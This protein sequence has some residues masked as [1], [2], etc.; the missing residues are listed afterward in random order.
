[1]DKDIW[2]FMLK[3]WEADRRILQALTCLYTTSFKCCK[4]AL[5]VGVLRV[6]CNWIIYICLHT[7]VKMAW[8]EYGSWSWE[9]LQQNGVLIPQTKTLPPA[10]DSLLNLIS[11]DCK[12]KC[13]L[14]C[15]YIQSDIACSTMWQ[16]QHS[17]S[18]LSRR[19]GHKQEL[20]LTLYFSEL[21][22]LLL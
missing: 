5:L 7:S 13:V 17:A 10:N 12:R 11:C 1:M 4:T 6:V 18:C 9:W 3:N 20:T 22:R 2:N 19:R 15:D 21:Q 16:L 8:K 14:T